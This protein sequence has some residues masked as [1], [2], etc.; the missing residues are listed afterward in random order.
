MQYLYH[1]TSQKAA[2]NIINDGLIMLGTFLSSNGIVME[3]SAISLTTDQDPIGHGLPDGREITKKQAEALK[4]HTI[5]NGKLHAINNT[6]CRITI[7]PSGLNI[8]S[9]IDYYATNPALLHSLEFMGYYP[10]G[11]DDINV[12]NKNKTFKS[13]APT[14]YYSFAPI[15][16]SSNVISFGIDITGDGKNYE[17]LSPSDF[18][19]LCQY[20]HQ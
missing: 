20:I 18:Q 6:K 12:I 1:F 9:A 10:V 4:Y 14:W 17:E 3:N 16:V 8:V 7:A 11:I 2:E 19:Q 15:N 5:I 13:K